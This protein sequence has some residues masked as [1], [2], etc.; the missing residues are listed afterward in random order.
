MNGFFE[1]AFTIK[2]LVARCARAL[3]KIGSIF[4]PRVI[5][6]S[7][8]YTSTIK[9]GDWATITVRAIRKGH[10]SSEQYLSISFPDN[11]IVNNIQVSSSDFSE[12]KVKIY[13]PRTSLWAGY[14]KFKITSSYP[15]VEGWDYPWDNGETH[16]LQVRVKPEK[17]G[18]FVFYVKGLALDQYGKFQSADPASGIT[19]QQGEYV[20]SYQIEVVYLAHE[21]RSC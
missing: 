21:H 10:G 16:F 12:T 5:V 4:L 20:Y 9:L 8:E 15:L 14:G 6:L 2:V 19:D 18:K 7:V 1:G 11:P 17:A 3:M 13:P